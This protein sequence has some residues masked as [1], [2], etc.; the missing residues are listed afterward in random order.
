MMLMMILVDIQLATDLACDMLVVCSDIHVLGSPL[1]TAEATRMQDLASEFSKIFQGWHPG[2]HCGRGRPLPA[3]TPSPGLWPGDSAP[4]LGPQPWS[5]STFQP[6][7]LPCMRSI[8]GWYFS[9]NIKLDSPVHARFENCVLFPCFHAWK[10]VEQT[11]QP[12]VKIKRNS[13]LTNRTWNL[14]LKRISLE[15]SWDVFMSP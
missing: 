6:W 2:P 5:P 3:P 11:Y 8:T 15:S 7:L 9:S 1:M 10:K 4:V 13:I 14:L 12:R